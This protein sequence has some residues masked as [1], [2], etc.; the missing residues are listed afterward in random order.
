MD[1]T[2]KTPRRSEP[3]TVG[4]IADAVVGNTA[5]RVIDTYDVAPVESALEL[6]ELVRL[7]AELTWAD[8]KSHPRFKKDRVIRE[9]QRR[10]GVA[11]GEAPLLPSVI[12]RG[13]AANDTDVPEDVDAALGAD[14]DFVTVCDARRDG[15]I[16]AMESDGAND[17]EAAAA[18]RTGG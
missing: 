8:W 6:E 10:W 4:N 18:R 15:W 2:R 16:E 11:S 9:A 7:R 14:P 17:D 3:K 5:S 13:V 1:D 12:A